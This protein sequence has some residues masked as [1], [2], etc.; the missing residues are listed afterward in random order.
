MYRA[1]FC[2][3]MARKIS[4]RSAISKRRSFPRV[5]SRLSTPRRTSRSSRT[6]TVIQ[7]SMASSTWWVR[8]VCVLPIIISGACGSCGARGAC[9]TFTLDGNNYI[10]ILCIGGAL[11]EL[12]MTISDWPRS[13]WYY[14]AAAAA[15]YLLIIIEIAVLIYCF[16]DASWQEIQYLGPSRQI[17]SITQT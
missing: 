3:P 4:P 8:G 7:R 13:Q 14:A 2:S 6:L 9:G 10:M 15:V 12:S 11:L 1:Y 5:V 16:Y 17:I